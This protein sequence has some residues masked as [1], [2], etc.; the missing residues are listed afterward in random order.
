MGQW[1]SRGR[2]DILFQFQSGAI[3]STKSE[4]DSAIAAGFQFQSGAIQ[5]LVPC[6][7]HNP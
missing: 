5:S 7:T 3:Q 1:G 4:V 6:N 2:V